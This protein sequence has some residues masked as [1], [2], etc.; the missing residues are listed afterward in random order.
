MDHLFWVSL[1]GIVWI[2][3]LLSGDNAVVIAL[4]SRQLP[5]NQQKWGIIGGTAAA[6]GLRVVMSFFA[7]YLLN[8]PLLSI[9]GGAYLLKVAADLIIG[10]GDEREPGAVTTLKAAIITIALA[11][12]SMSLDNVMAIAALSHGNAAL[13][14]F[15]VLLSIPMVI[16]GAAV[17]SMVIGRFPILTW[18]GAA[19]LGWV[20]GGIISSDPWASPYLNHYAASAAGLLIVLAIGWCFSSDKTEAVA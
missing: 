1:L 19:L 6:I 8:I 9:L 10:G 20:A 7:A 16:V 4:V 3:L 15:G 14:A 2:D 18:A 13:M 5:E 11:D 17:I 12:A